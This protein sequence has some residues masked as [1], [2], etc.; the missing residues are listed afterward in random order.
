MTGLLSVYQGKVAATDTYFLFS[1]SC[2]AYD[3]GDLV[4]VIFPVDEPSQG[5]RVGVWYP[6][7]LAISG[8]AVVSMFFRFIAALHLFWFVDCFPLTYV[9]AFVASHVLDP[10]LPSVINERVS[11]HHY[12]LRVDGCHTLQT[13]SICLNANVSFFVRDSL[14]FGF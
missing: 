3:E 11:T 5:W 2:K 9:A 6:Q 14:Q 12:R 10:R 8:S 1:H 7:A 13:V 4:E